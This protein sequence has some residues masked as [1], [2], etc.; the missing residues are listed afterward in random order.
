MGENHCATTKEKRAAV[1]LCT[2][3]RRV[4]AARLL[5]FSSGVVVEVEGVMSSEMSRLRK[6]VVTNSGVDP[7][8]WT[9]TG[10]S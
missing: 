2:T 7:V 8:F 6:P 9:K 1:S 5:F 4:V 10:R 3:W